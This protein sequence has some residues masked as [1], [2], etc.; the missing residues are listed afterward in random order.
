MTVALEAP[1]PVS[2]HVDAE[3]LTRV[4]GNVVGNAVKYSL[5]GGEVRV[6]VRPGD[7]YVEMVCEDDGVGISEDEQSVV[8]DI[9]RRGRERGDGVPGAGMGLAI[10]HRI[11]TR[12]G[13]T[14]ALSSTPGHGSRF[15]VR[16]PVTPSTRPAS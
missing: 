16:I 1:G 13:G 11:V 2:A 14:I 7:G 8:F 5:P 9:M 15:S 12:L 10:S 3:V 6:R 4:Y